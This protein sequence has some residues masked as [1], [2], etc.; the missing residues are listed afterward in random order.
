MTRARVPDVARQ[1]A[2]EHGVQPLH[3]RVVDVTG[4]APRLQQKE[5]IAKQGGRIQIVR[6]ALDEQLH[7]RRVRFVLLAPSFHVE[8]FDVT[9]R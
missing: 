9:H 7:R 4:A 1:H 2:L 8:V 6:I 5:R 3:A